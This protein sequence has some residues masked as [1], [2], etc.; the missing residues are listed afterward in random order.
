MDRGP[1]AEMPPRFLCCE[2]QNRREQLTK[3]AK[4]F[5]HCALGRASPSRVRRVAIHPVF[6][7][8]DIKR[9]QIDRTEVIER[10][11]DLMKLKRFVSGSTIGN[12]SVESLQNPPINQ[13]KISCRECL[14]QMAR[15][16][17]RS[18]GILL[19]FL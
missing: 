7:D 6:R 9:A 3:S 18:R 14:R 19:R 16:S 4:D 12:H 5:V 17:E 8:V 13:R 2:S 15:H 11:I 1:G 10:V